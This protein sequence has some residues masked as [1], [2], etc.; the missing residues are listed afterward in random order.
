MATRTYVDVFI[1][2]DTKFR[3][4]LNPDVNSGQTVVVRIDDN[5]ALMFDNVKRE[6]LQRLIAVLG[7]ARDELPED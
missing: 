1:P 6:T 2:E 3:Y 4:R 7:E 5:I